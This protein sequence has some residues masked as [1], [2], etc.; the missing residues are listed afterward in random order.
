MNGV[1]VYVWLTGLLDF[2]SSRQITN[3]SPA[4]KRHFTGQSYTLS[5]HDIYHTNTINHGERFKDYR[6]SGYDLGRGEGIFKMA[7]SENL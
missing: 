4:D 5:K 1:L 6:Q 3:D 2:L 7:G